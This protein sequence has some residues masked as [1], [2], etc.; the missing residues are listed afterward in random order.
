MEE[1]N[2]LDSKENKRK[3][4]KNYKMRKL[5]SVNSCYRKKIKLFLFATAYTEYSCIDNM[6]IKFMCFVTSGGR[7]YE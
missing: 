6:L 1:K 3:E 7:D 2:S 5:D 4:K